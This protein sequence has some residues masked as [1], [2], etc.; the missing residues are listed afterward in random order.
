M[1]RVFGREETGMTRFRVVGVV[2]GLLHV[3]AAER[4]VCLVGAILVFGRLMGSMQ[5]T[6]VEDYDFGVSIIPMNV[7]PV[8]RGEEGTGGEVM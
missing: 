6:C 8:F 7:I 1:I 4:P 3:L 5:G 2:S